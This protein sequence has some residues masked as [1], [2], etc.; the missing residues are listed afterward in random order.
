MDAVRKYLRKEH[1]DIELQL[2]DPRSVTQGL[3]PFLFVM[4]LPIDLF[5]STQAVPVVDAA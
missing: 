3:Y 1:G 5:A 2:I 4:R